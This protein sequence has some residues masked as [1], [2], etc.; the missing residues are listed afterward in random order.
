MF[1]RHA[2]R[3]AYPGHLYMVFTTIRFI[4]DLTFTNNTKILFV[5][6]D[7]EQMCM[8]LYA[9]YNI[10]ALFGFSYAFR[11]DEDIDAHSSVW[12][13]TKKTKFC[14]PMSMIYFSLATTFL[15]WY[16]LRGS[17][18]WFVITNVYWNIYMCGS[19]LLACHNPP[20]EASF[21]HL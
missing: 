4:T 18:L 20:K 21:E 8:Y 6:N 2:L 14:V 9:F 5:L 3:I 16:N 15:F 17:G 13:W 1:V 19:M 7:S 10:V 11:N 12:E